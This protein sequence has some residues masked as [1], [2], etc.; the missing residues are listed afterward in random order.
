MSL[1][2]ETTSMSI[3]AWL[4]E[5]GKLS[6]AGV[7][8]IT[9]PASLP[10]TSVKGQTIPAIFESGLYRKHGPESSE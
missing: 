6:E 2:P 4:E 5:V 3:G 9:M 1:E 8:R 10:P 7:S